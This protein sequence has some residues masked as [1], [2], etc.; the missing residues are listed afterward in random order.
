MPITKL[1]TQ[2]RREIV[3]KMRQG[4]GPTKLSHEYGVDRVRIHQ[5]YREAIDHA[6][7]KAR[8]AEAEAKFRKWVVKDLT[9]L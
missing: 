3:T 5:V 7:E 4:V 9:N 8:E 1:N 6:Q 2:Q